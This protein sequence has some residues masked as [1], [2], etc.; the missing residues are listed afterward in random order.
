MVLYNHYRA[1]KSFECLK[2]ITFTTHGEFQYMDNLIPLLRKWR[3]PL[4]VAVFAPGYGTYVQSS[5]RQVLPIDSADFI[6]NTAIVLFRTAG[7]KI[8]KSPGKKNHEIK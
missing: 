4:S 2:S 7:Q 6:S 1:R 8:K 3:G 5:Y